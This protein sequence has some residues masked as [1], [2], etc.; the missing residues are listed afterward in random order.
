MSDKTRFWIL[1]VLLVLSLALLA[2]AVTQL[3]HLNNVN[4]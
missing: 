1:I 3:G 2:L 4:P